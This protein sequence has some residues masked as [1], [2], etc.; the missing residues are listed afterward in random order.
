MT[1]IILYYV[2]TLLNA[3]YKTRLLPVLIKIYR[4]T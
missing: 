1:L 4:A 3:E 2:R